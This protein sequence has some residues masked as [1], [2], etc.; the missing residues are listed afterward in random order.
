MERS[1]TLNAEDWHQLAKMQRKLRYCSWLICRVLPVNFQCVSEAALALTP[2]IPL[3]V[4]LSPFRHP[5]PTLITQPHTHHP[6]SM[7]CPLPPLLLS[8]GLMYEW[9][10]YI[11][12]TRWV[13]PAGW[14]GKWLRE[15]RRHHMLHHMRNENFWLSFSAPQGRCVVCVG[16]GVGSNKPTITA[17]HFAIAHTNG[18]HTQLPTSCVSAHPCVCPTCL[19]WMLYVYVCVQLMRCSGRYHSAAPAYP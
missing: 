7:N 16:G 9:L 13:P 6:M 5:L 17:G 3:T 1:R 2:C 12:H 14:R 10:H 8:I 19:C 4:C 15:V 11:V 18:L